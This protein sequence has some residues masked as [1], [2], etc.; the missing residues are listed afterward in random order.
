MHKGESTKEKDGAHR[1]LKILVLKM[2][3]CSYKQRLEVRNRFF[4]RALEGAR[5]CQHLDSSPVTLILDF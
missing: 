2:E 4:P 1:D 3:R 5:S